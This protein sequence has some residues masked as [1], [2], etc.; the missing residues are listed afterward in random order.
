MS[1]QTSWRNR[2]NLSN[3][4]FALRNPASVYGQVTKLGVRFNQMFHRS[5][6][7]RESLDFMSE[8]WDTM[9]ILDGCRADM[10]NEDDLPGTVQTRRSPASQSIEF[11]H[12]HFQ[13]DLYETV[14]VTAN[15]HAQYEIQGCFHYVD[16][17]YEDGWDDELGTVRP[18]TVRKRAEAALDKFPDK[19]LVVHFM[20]PHFPF[21]GP[22]G[23]Q[24][25][26]RGIQQPTRNREGT[27][28]ADIDI[29]NQLQYRVADVS[30]ET[31]ER[32]YRENL[33]IVL[34][35]IDVLLRKE[36]GRT[37]VTADHGNLLGERLWPLP[38]RGY[39]HP[40]HLY[41]DPLVQVPWIVFE[42][43]PRPD[44]RPEEPTVQDPRRRRL[45][46]SV[47]NRLNDLG[48][49]GTTD[50]ESR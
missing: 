9:L 3:L 41:V 43:G 21:I 28:T 35:E 36:T 31:V 34:K 29:W 16:H 23:R 45:D 40:K 48:Y 33:E 8:D 42:N 13:R 17:V 15:P 11:M 24:I 46:E 39:G 50:H 10:L 7:D 26:Q 1:R 49:S 18:D 47:T 19:R 4:F 30:L 5:F 12:E 37:V 2:Y 44:V 38:V 22:T 6:V 14:Y 32:A 27:G 25:S 20:Q